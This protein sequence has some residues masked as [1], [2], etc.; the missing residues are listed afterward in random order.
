[1]AKIYTPKERREIEKAIVFI[2]ERFL[3]CQIN[4]KP[5]ILHSIMVGTKLMELGQSKNVVIAGFLHDLV[6]DSDTSINDVK[7]EFGSKVAKL[8]GSLTMDCEIKDYKPRYQKF[9]KNVIKAGQEAILIKI[10]DQMDNL[11]YYAYVLDSDKQQE[12]FWKHQFVFNSLKQYLSRK[13]IFEEYKRLLK[14]IIK[15]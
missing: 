6:E 1:M 7:E 2:T 8:V 4:E 13:P 15:A 12:L 5:V 11:P 14:K 9:I 3:K 10:I